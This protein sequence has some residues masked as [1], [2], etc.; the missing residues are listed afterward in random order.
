MFIP[1]NIS[2]QQFFLRF[3]NSTAFVYFPIYNFFTNNR[4]QFKINIIFR[5]ETFRV[6][7]FYY[8]IDCQGFTMHGKQDDF[9]IWEFFPD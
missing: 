6:Y 1:I 3:Y 8:F 2:I 5:N 9:T 4:E 7:V